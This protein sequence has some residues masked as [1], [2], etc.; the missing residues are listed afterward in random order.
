MF[1]INAWANE[2]LRPPLDNGT[3]YAWWDVQ[4]KAI[5]SLTAIVAVDHDLVTG[6][7]TEIHDLHNW[8]ENK[9]AASQASGK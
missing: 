3:D 7:R 6:M 2:I 4:E 5:A 1:Q 9:P 8:Y